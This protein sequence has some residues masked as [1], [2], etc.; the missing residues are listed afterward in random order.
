L[1]ADQ[2]VATP[3]QIAQQKGIN[4]S[5]HGTCSLSVNY[6]AL[7]HYFRQNGEQAALTAF[8]HPSFAVMGAVTSQLCGPCPLTLCAFEQ[9]IGDFEPA[10][11]WKLVSE[12]ETAEASLE[13]LFLLLKLGDWDP[14]NLQLYVERLR[15]LL[16]FVEGEEKL[17]WV[18]AIELSYDNFFPINFDEMSVVIN[19]GVLLFEM[20][21]YRRALNFFQ[22]AFVAAGGSAALWFN[23]G[24]C[25]LGLEDRDSALPCFVQ[26][27]K[28]DPA[29]NREKR[30]S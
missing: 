22:R 1:T 23:M 7:K 16:R 5:K 30:F 12:C 9:Q 4:L 26:A 3:W 10:D 14:T 25:F 15:P 29:Y 27:E 8:P 20:K 24:L 11:Y 18:Q 13:R 19:M 17:K 2:G 6:L 28:L 21:E